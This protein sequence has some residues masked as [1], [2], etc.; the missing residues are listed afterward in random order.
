MLLAYY[1]DFSVV[2]LLMRVCPQVTLK[3]MVMT[4]PLWTHGGLDTIW[5]LS[6]RLELVDVCCYGYDLAQILFH[7][8]S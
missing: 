4:L 8:Y 6:T 5:V 7:C 1:Y 2:L 3:S